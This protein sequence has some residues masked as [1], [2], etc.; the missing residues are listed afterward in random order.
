[1]LHYSIDLSRFMV[2]VKKV[3]YN[4][5]NR[6]V[7]EVRRPNPSNQTRSSRGG[8]RRTFRVVISPD[9]RRGIRVQGILTLRGVQHV[10]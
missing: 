9:L 10:K 5:K 2:H 1:M 4:R 3:E 6:R 7:H 8:G